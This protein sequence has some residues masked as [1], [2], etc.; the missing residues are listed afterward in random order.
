MPV[1]DRELLGAAAS[2]VHK[3]ACGDIPKQA[4]TECN[5]RL[6]VIR[7]MACAAFTA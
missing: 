3:A 6:A 4:F 2:S 5:A 7:L 1:P